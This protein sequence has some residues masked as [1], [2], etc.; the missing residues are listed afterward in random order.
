MDSCCVRSW[1]WADVAST[2][3]HMHV[4]RMH[5]YLLAHPF[6][7][8]IGC[9]PFPHS[10]TCLLFLNLCYSFLACPLPSATAQQIRLQGHMASMLPCRAQV[11]S[12]TPHPLS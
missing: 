3:H 5:M 2:P 11:C 9:C 8:C 10:A 12:V 4:T 1:Q 7:I 6:P